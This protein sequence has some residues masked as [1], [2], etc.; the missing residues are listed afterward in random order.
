VS[1]VQDRRDDLRY[2]SHV[3]LGNTAVPAQRRLDLKIAL[4]VIVVRLCAQRDF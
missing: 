4:G 3:A 2:V 1:A